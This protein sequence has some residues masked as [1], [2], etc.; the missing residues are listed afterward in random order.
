VRATFF[1]L[2]TLIAVWWVAALPGVL[3]PGRGARPR[4]VVVIV[5]D[6]LRADYLDRQAA[7]FL[8]PGEIG[9]DAGGFAYLRERGASFPAARYRH[10]PLQ[11]G[12]GHATVLTGGYPYQTGIVANDW[13]SRRDRAPVYCVA[14]LAARVVGAAPGSR[15]KPMSPANLR[16]TTVGD[17]L[18]MA[19]GGAARVVSLSLKDRSAILMAGRLADAVCWFDEDTGR[20]ISSSPYCKSGQ[21]PS[22]IEAVNAQRLP[23][24]YFGR[25]WRPLLPAGNVPPLWSP[26]APGEV[27]A[28]ASLGDHFPHRVDG[29]LRSPGPDYFQAFIR[30]P[31]ANEFLLETARAAVHAERMGQDEVPDLL[32][33]SL[34]T[35][36]YVG[37]LFGPD[38]PEVADATVQTDRQLAAFFRFLDGAVPG[39]LQ[40]VT[41]ALTADH[42]VAPVPERM[43]AAGF[44]AGRVSGGMVAA[45]AKAALDRRFG[46]RE[47]V[48]KFLTPNLYLDP[49][50]VAAAGVDPE[51]VQASAA[52]ALGDLEGIYAAYPARSIEQGRLPANEIAARISRSFH[53]ERS[54]DVVVVT[55]PLWFTSEGSGNTT[56]HGTPY[57]YDTDV[58]LLLAGFGIRPGAYWSPASPNDLAPTL[59]G[60][61]R[62]ARPAACEG[63]PLAPALER[64]A[65]S[66]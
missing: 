24:R 58:P 31:Y 47:W 48:A 16:S 66:R 3:P 46:E 39:G 34:S 32:A 2:L 33:I 52:R 9:G 20:W 49:D 64:E 5:V 50:V 8:P 36:D 37:H 44:D 54:G 35:N 13:Y 30:T 57:A 55:D 53:P 65:G 40:N 4:L 26:G 15:A 22:W 27:D 41:V 63:L 14:D 25:E 56:T 10:L 28:P 21:L 1:L 6:Q 45:W 18:K 23:D 19:T 12:P 62:V 59:C 17:E 38:S 60:L 7:S 29:G 43:A 51:Q 61:L 42:G 11:T